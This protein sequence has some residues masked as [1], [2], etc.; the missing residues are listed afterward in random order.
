M[1]SKLVLGLTRVL[2]AKGLITEAE[3]LAALGQGPKKSD[4]S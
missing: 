1:P 3:I 2:L 4:K